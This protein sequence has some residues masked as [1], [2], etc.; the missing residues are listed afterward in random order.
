MSDS[1]RGRFFPPGDSATAWNVVSR[2]LL[3]AFG[4]WWL[5]IEG[6]ECAPDDVARLRAL[7]GQAAVICPNHPTLGEPMA[8]AT[9]CADA[10][11]RPRFVMDIYTLRMLGP[12]RPLFQAAGCYSLRRGTADRDSFAQTR[13]LLVADRQVVLFPEGETYGV[14][15]KLLPFHEGV[16]QIGLWGLQDRVKA[17]L[18]PD[19]LLVPVAVKYLWRGDRTDTIDASLERLE[20]RLAIVPAPEL[21]RYARLRRVGLAFVDL[22]LRREGVAPPAEATLDE[23]IESAFDHLLSRVARTM[24][25]ELTPGGTLQDQLRRL[26]NVVD[27]QIFDLLDEGDS[28]YERDLQRQAG[29]AW[30]AFERDLARLQCFQAVRDGYVASY[31]SAER[32]L[33]VLDRL[34]REVCGRAPRFG[35]RR[36]IVRVGEPLHLGEYWE[37]YRA[38]R[39]GTLTAITAELR[40]RVAALAEELSA[41]APRIDPPRNTEP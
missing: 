29:P 16:A 8:V 4:R 2:W 17:E 14:N 26:Y 15:D 7:D 40:G 6:V 34:E 5:H 21:H 10:G 36:A 28:P 9:A 37:A 30:R 12:L 31:P 19:V 24:Q 27:E 35:R 13:R 11:L 33:D 20:R 23:R 1:G 22:Q 39:H 32:Y 3:P 38:D 18:T 25:V 41:R